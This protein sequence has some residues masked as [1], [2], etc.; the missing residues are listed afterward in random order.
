MKPHKCEPAE[1]IAWVW[2]TC[3]TCK[4]KIEPVYCEKCDGTGFEVTI[5]HTHSPCKS[6]SGTGIKKWR[7]V[8]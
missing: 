2:F 8:K 3:K 6:C 4:R 1:P 7:K 5:G